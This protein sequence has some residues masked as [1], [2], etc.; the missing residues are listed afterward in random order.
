MEVAVLALPFPAEVV[1]H[2]LFLF[3]SWS[4]D[5]GHRM[6][7]GPRLGL[8][9]P[10]GWDL[11]RACCCAPEVL[12]GSSRVAA[13]GCANVMTRQERSLPSSPNQGKCCL[14]ETVPLQDT[15]T[16]P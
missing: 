15:P 8:R 5:G 3:S 16:P 12:W 2:P 14:A 1:L 6:G 11:L 4:T 10:G 13:V 9:L 7:G